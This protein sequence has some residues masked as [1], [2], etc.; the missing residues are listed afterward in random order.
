MS[1]SS[2]ILICLGNLMLLLFLLCISISAFIPHC[3]YLQNSGFHIRLWTAWWQRH[4][5]LFLY[6]QCL[7]HATKFYMTNKCYVELNRWHA[8]YCTTHVYNAQPKWLLRKAFP[9]FLSGLPDQEKLFSL[10]LLFRV[11]NAWDI[12]M[13]KYY[14]SSC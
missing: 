14:S 12:N 6:S 8:K 2:K 4:Y 9:N 3:H 7:P 11:H 10:S 13:Y 1:Y 5:H